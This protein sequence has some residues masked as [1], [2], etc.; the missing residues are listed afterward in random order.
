MSV[1]ALISHFHLI[2]FSSEPEDVG[3]EE[4]SDEEDSL[5]DMDEGFV[6]VQSLP[7]HLHDVDE[8]ALTDADMQ[9]LLSDE[10]MMRDFPDWTPCGVK[11]RQ[12]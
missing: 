10:A 11:T 9:E 8:M 2:D 1:L 4:E 6:G 7:G 5:N 12:L 3:E